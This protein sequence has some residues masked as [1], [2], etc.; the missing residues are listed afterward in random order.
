MENSSLIVLLYF[1]SPTS[2]VQLHYLPWQF[3]CCCQSFQLQVYQLPL[4]PDPLNF[5]CWDSDDVQAWTDMSTCFSLCCPG[6]AELDKIHCT[7]VKST[8]GQLSVS[9]KNPSSCSSRLPC[10]FRSDDS[11]SCL[12]LQAPHK[13]PALILSA[14]EWV[15]CVQRKLRWWTPSSCHW[16]LF[17]SLF[18]FPTAPRPQI[19]KHP[20][21][22]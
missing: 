2:S 7:S 18:L 15:V 14:Y 19:L 8:V 13:A 22:Q 21:P 12:Y 6:E 9:L 3:G 5:L 20:G 16:N 11:Q 1:L 10:L 17:T 4:L